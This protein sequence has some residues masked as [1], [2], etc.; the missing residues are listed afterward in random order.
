MSEQLV[1]M[2]I[3]RCSLVYQG[4]GMTRDG[5][6]SSVWI[7]SVP[8]PASPAGMCSA[9]TVSYPMRLQVLG[10]GE[11]CTTEMAR[12]MR[13]KKEVAGVQHAG[14]RSLWRTFVHCMTIDQLFARTLSSSSHLSFPMSLCGE[15]LG[16]S[17]GLWVFPFNRLVALIEAIHSTIASMVPFSAIILFLI[18]SGSC[19]VHAMHCNEV[20]LIKYWGLLIQNKIITNEAYVFVKRTPTGRIYDQP[21]VQHFVAAH[22][23][24]IPGVNTEA[25][26]DIMEFLAEVHETQ[27]A[28]DIAFSAGKPFKTICQTGLNTGISALAFLCATKADPTIIVHSFDLGNHAYAKTAHE[29]LNQIYPNRHFV[30]FGSSV[31]TL[32]QLVQSKGLTCDYVFIDGG[33]AQ[34]V[35]KA[36]IMNFKALSSPGTTVVMENCNM[37]N[38]GHGFGGMPAVSSQYIQAGTAPPLLLGMAC[39]TLCVQYKIR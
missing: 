9:G 4:M 10:R 32:P 16:F 23:T 20:D 30:T 5:A 19:G 36:D 7:R 3:R 11:Q 22:N 29:L 2:R 1:I 34:D 33:H 25:G 8:L 35:A 14:Q 24:T 38:A 39:L 28:R 37:W 31:E 26:T 27:L 12:D 21:A 13:W 6:V 18:L 17:C 15:P